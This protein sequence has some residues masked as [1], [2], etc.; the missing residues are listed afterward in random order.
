MKKLFF[1]GL[2]LGFFISCGKEIKE[3]S[4]EDSTEAN[5]DQ[6]KF[7]P[8]VAIT[9]RANDSIKNWPEFKAFETSFDAVYRI[10]NKADLSLAIE[11]LIEKQKLLD[12]SVYPKLFDN[13]QIKSRQKVLKTFI[14]KTKGNLEYQ[15]DTREATIEMINAYNALRNQF[16]V[17]VNNT[18]DTKLI[19]DE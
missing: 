5:F 12:A 13:P 10:E 17:M 1:V 18:I 8:K 16:N 14:L 6:K 2:I 11:D 4:T 19:F 15:M 9:S 3:V 7:P